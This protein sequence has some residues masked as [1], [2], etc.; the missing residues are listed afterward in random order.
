MLRLR[1]LA[2]LFSITAV[3]TVALAQTNQTFETHAA[4]FSRETNQ[5][6]PID[7][8]VFVPESTAAAAVGPQNIAHAAGLR[9]ALPSDAGTLE[10]HNAQGKDLGF[11]LAAWFGATG[12]AEMTPAA[13]GHQRVVLH[14]A[15]L[16]PSGVYSMFENHFAPSGVTFTPLDGSGRGNSFTADAQ[17]AATATIDA[18][19]PFTHAN[20]LLLVYHSDGQTHGTERGTLG[21]NVHHQL[22]VRFP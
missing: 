14:F 2:T 6:Q 18:P 21:V 1:V 16:V 5:A 9:N 10:A 15:H 22:I 13:N 4:F 12:T 7:P 17:G 11:T 19:A 3:T 8:Q 20:A